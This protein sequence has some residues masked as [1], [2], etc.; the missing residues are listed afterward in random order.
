MECSVSLKI[1]G[2]PRT[3]DTEQKKLRYVVGGLEN[4]ALIQIMPYCDKVSREVKL[5]L[6]KTLVDTLELVFG[7]QDKAATA[8]REL[9]RLRQSDCG[10]IELSYVKK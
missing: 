8:K 10:Q 5:D 4:V 1:A 2:K 6:F 9:L 3:F 7:D